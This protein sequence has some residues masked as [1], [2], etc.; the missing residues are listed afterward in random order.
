MTIATTEEKKDETVAIAANDVDAT[1]A[2]DDTAKEDEV[3]VEDNDGE[4]GE[5]AE[6]VEGAGGDEEVTKKKRKKVRLQWFG[7][8]EHESWLHFLIVLLDDLCSRRRRRKRRKM[9][10]LEC[11]RKSPM[12]AC[13]ETTV[14]QIIMSR[15]VRR[16]HHR[17]QCQ[18]CLSQKVESS[19]WVKLWNIL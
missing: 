19:L 6:I 17:F 15:M 16:I 7:N 2:K 4:D 11:H 12:A 5:D 13:W 9:V 14:S 1:V 8:G 3:N 18:P 10:V